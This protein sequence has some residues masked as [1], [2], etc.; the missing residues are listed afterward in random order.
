MTRPLAP[1]RIRD[2]RRCNCIR[3]RWGLPIACS[4]GPRSREAVQRG[5]V[6]VD[7]LGAVD[8]RKALE[9]P[10]DHLMAARECAL[11]VGIIATPHQTVA[12]GELDVPKG[13][14][15]VAEGDESLSL[16]VF[17]R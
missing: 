15:I 5:S 3:P 17:A 14:R 2:R 12:S 1:S 11:V 13:H 16:E 4:R 6:V 7:D 9:R 10:L 8:V